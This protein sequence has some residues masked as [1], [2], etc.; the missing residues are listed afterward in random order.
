ML[1]LPK[2]SSRFYIGDNVHYYITTYEA[3][4]MQ[5]AQEGQSYKEI[6]SLLSMASTTVKTHLRRLEARTGLSFQ[7][8]SLQSFQHYKNTKNRV[9]IKNDLEKHKI[10][11]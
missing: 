11:I 7:E 4:C 10:K 5:L 1:F 6:G 8:I 3:L 9:N 2:R